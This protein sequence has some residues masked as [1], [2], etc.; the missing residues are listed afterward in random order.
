MD[1]L[2]LACF[3]IG[4]SW[5][6]LRFIPQY[7]R[8]CRRSFELVVAKVV[9]MEERYIHKRG[10]AYA[11]VYQYE[12]DGE[13]YQRVYPDSALESN[14]FLPGR[15]PAFSVGSFLTVMVDR[16]DPEY[17]VVRD[18]TRYM[19]LWKGLVLSIVGCILFG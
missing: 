14:R 5:S 7:L 13:V 11:P 8:D 12:Y 15:S 19:P 2:L 1:T 17:A 18:Y 4:G 9:Y 6:I 10:I 3:L 16:D